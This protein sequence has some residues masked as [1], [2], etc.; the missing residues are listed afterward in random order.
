MERNLLNLKV[1]FS[2]VCMSVAMT[3]HAGSF[4]TFTFDIQR[5]YD[6]ETASRCQVSEAVVGKYFGL[7][8]GFTSQLSNSKVKILAYYYN[9]SGAVKTYSAYTASPYGYW[10]NAKGNPVNKIAQYCTKVTYSGGYFL[11]EHDKAN[12][13]KGETYTVM[14]AVVQPATADTLLY[15]FNVTLGDEDAVSTDQPMFIARHSE[16][17][18]WLVTPKVQRSDDAPIAENILQVMEGDRIS[19]GFDFSPVDTYVSV[20]Q[21]RIF[22]VEWDAKNKKNK[23]VAVT[24]SIKDTTSAVVSESAVQADAGRYL[25]KVTLNTEN[26]LF[27]TFTYT[28]YVDVQSEKAGSFHVWN[29]PKLSYDFKTEYPNLQQ[30]EKLHKIYKKGGKQVANSYAGEW[31]S[32]FWGDNLNSECG[33]EEQVQAAAKNLVDKYDYDFAYIRDSIGWPPDLS[34]RKGYKSFVYIFGSGLNNDSESN[35]TTGGYQSSTSADGQSWACVWASYYPFS[36]FRDD[37]D[38]KWSDGEYQRNA[39]VHEGIHATFADLSACQGSSWFHEGGNTWLQG[40]V[41]ARRDGVHGDAG[42]LDGGPFLA[43]HMPIE[44]YSGWLQDGSYGGPA[45]QGVNMYGPTGQVCTWR[46][47]LGGV[48][49]ANAFPTVIA[50]VCG[51]QSIAWIWRYCKNRVLET[52]GDTLGDEAMREIIVQYR[53]RQALFDL[54]GWDESY[55]AVTNSYFGTTQR[56]EWRNGV[57][58]QATNTVSGRN[59]SSDQMPCWIDVDPVIL[60]PY[61]GLTVNDDKGWLAPDT[62]TNPGWSGANQIP[63]HVNPD[64]DFV[65]IDFRPED[66]D[67]MALLCYRTKTGECYYSHP[68]HCGTMCLDI[69]QKPAN[70]VVFCVVV[71]TDYIYT[72]DAQR[73]HHWDYRLR[74]GKNAYQIASKDQKWYYYEKTITDPNYDPVGIDAVELNDENFQQAKS[75]RVNNGR[76]YAGCTLSTEL[77]GVDADDVTVRMVGAHGTV[78]K[79]S[80][81]NGDGTFTVPG[82]IPAGFYIISFDHNGRHDVYKVIVNR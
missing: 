31:W 80:R 28:Y 78:V 72:G 63:I 47:Y 22:H 71:N 62:L 35:T 45:A 55:R 32:V 79:S 26:G 40:Q 44:C 48:Q 15:V 11:V 75:V 73:K 17:D 24:K 43:P 74:L 5:S 66:T 34:A 27:K 6:S 21:F 18:G 37:A 14:E 42:F 20:K 59:S 49:Y 33:D 2:V 10:F 16:T 51:D 61:Q 1:L 60:T 38:Q 3:V 23:E 9:S 36:R 52:M 53:A 57:Y 29:A 41:Y 82:N 56:A 30:P 67:M 46:S 77:V 65:E 68:V 13:V 7:S 64:G 25:L 19:L 76:I 12:A 39:M 54:G 58:D 81:L 69:S 4:T 8:S 50:N 70:G